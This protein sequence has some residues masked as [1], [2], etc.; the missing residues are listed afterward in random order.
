MRFT[1]PGK[2]VPLHRARAGINRFYDDQFILKK[3]IRSHLKEQFPEGFKP[4]T[5]PIEVRYTFYM[6]LPKAVSNKRRKDLLGQPHDKTTDLSNL[7]KLVE[8]L[9][10]EFLW[11]DDRLI[12]KT[13]AKKVWAL[14]GKTVFSINHTKAIN[15]TTN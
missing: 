14:E 1:I 7:I 4:Y 15:K 11:E 3:N 12:W 9:G 10:N 13:S 8:D 2:P 6:P 5:E